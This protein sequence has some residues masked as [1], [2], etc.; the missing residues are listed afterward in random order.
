M[1]KKYYSEFLKGHQ[2]KIHMAGHSHH[3]WP[4]VSKKAHML[5]WEKAQSLSDTK[6]DYLLGEVLPGVQKIISTQLNLSRPQDIAFASNTHE[7]IVRM[8]SCFLHKKKIKILT[9]NCEFHSLSRQLKRLSEEEQFEI[10]YLDAQSDNFNSKIKEV[11]ESTDFDLIFMS[12]VFFNTGAILAESS[13]RL[14]IELKKEAHFI[15]DA[16]HGFCAI[17]T[18]LSSFEDDLYYMAGGYKYAQAG[19]GMCFITLPKNCTLRPLFTGWFSSFETLEDT[20]TNETKYSDNGMRF[21]GSTLD[22]TAFIR[23]KEIWNHFYYNSLDIVLFHKYIKSL[24][25][26]FINNNKLSPKFVSIK[27][28][29][30]GH[31]ITAKMDSPEQAKQLYLELMKNSIITDHRAQYLRFGFTPYLNQEDIEEVKSIINS[32]SWEHK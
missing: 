28:H 24:Q 29:E 18:D 9:T 4:D 13:I 32:F 30:F 10:T 31:F 20:A 26:Q 27:T 6:W 22:M 11:L 25:I 12:H 2:G 1:F 14:I 8:I 15:L 7:L 5:S 19:E 23:F 16:Y 21:W 17:P 3:F